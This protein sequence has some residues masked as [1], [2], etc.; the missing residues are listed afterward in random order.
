MQA[1]LWA[2]VVGGHACARYFL[3]EEHSVVQVKSKESRIESSG[4][5]QPV[6]K[7]SKFLLLE[8]ML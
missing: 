8:N 4:M 2:A 5:Y 3:L 6:F 7:F 1:T